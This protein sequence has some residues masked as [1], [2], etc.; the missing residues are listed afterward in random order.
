MTFDIP[1]GYTSTRNKGIMDIDFLPGQNIKIVKRQP[2]D[3][4]P[5]NMSPS[6]NQEASTGVT[7]KPSQPQNMPKPDQQDETIAKVN[8]DK[9]K[10]PLLPKIADITFD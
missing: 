3:D 7:L 8:E 1:Q 4:I 2:E 5:D 10:F 9:P 6:S